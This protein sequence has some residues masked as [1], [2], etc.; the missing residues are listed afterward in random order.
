MDAVFSIDGV[1]RLN[2]GCGDSGEAGWIN[3]D[4]KDGP[5]I[6]IT[7]DI[8]DGLPLATDSLDYIVSIHALPMIPLPTIGDILRELRRML[9]PGAVLR[10]GLPDLDRSIQAYLR[11]DRGYFLVPDTHIESYGG[12]FVSHILWYGYTVTLFT[13]D[14]IEELLWKAGFSQV[15]HCSFKQTHS[16]L[17]PGILELDNRERESLFVEAVK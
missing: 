10:L 14:F 12:Q 8:R 6:Q 1:R 17:A 3:S 15:V 2:W 11:R 4:L 9:K 7:A 5:G 13:P 16:S